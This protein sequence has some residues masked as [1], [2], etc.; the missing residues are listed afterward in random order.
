M[1]SGA[2]LGMCGL[3][4]RHP[5]LSLAT[6]V[7]HNQTIGKHL[8]IGPEGPSFNIDVFRAGNG[9][10]V[11]LAYGAPLGFYALS[12]ERRPRILGLTLMRY[13]KT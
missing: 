9:P 8:H 4:S 5:L 10:I 2:F 12:L 7:A 13:P 11:R 3:I 1:G 6:E